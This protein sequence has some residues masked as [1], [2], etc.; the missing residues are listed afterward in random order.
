M[1]ESINNNLTVV[2]AAVNK[3]EASTNTK[4]SEVEKRHQ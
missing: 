3:L 2:N 4:L 1:E